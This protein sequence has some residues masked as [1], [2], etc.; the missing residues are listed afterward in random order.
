MR[1]T[2][3]FDMR[4]PDPGDDGARLYAAMLDICAWADGLG[5]EEVFIGEHHGAEDG[6]IPCPI[7]LASAVAAR[8]RRIKLHISALLVTMYHPLRLAEDLAVLDIISSGRVR[9]TCG[10]GYRP[11]EFEMF[12]VDIKKRLRIYL[13]TLATLE[14]AW[15]GE[16]FEFEGRTVRVTPRPVQRPGPQV[17]MGGSTEASA[18]RAARL[19][20]AFMPGYPPYYE[21]YRQELRSLGRPEPPPLPNQAPNFLYV[22]DD[23]EHAWAT[24]GPFALYTA[25]SYARWNAERGA[26]ATMY[27]G[28]QTLEQARHNP[29]FQI[30]TPE[31]CLA[32][33]E[34]L[35]PNGELQFQPLFGGLDPQLAW[36]SL[37]LFEREVLPRMRAKGLRP[38][39]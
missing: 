23:P 10:M 33:A 18:Q 26:G 36:K 22:T 3:R 4:K 8:T 2:L 13:S 39:A 5:F 27:A 37:E 7:V 24:I 31:Q 1:L 11:H 34:S 21:T 32:F 29:M 12:G 25:N 35:E 16:P 30:V 28:E 19:G 20:Y 15:T 9:M 38:A 6:Y 14:Q 17:I